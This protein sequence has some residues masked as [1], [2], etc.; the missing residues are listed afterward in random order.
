[1]K[2][3]GAIRAIIDATIRGDQIDLCS[4]SKAV[5]RKRIVP[6]IRETAQGQVSPGLENVEA[7]VIVAVIFLRLDLEAMPL[8]QRSACG[9]VQAALA[10]TGVPWMVIG[11]SRSSHAA[12]AG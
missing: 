11:G 8:P 9:P 12:C 5:A 1:V 3:R 7:V 10:T 2:R 4:L 6:R